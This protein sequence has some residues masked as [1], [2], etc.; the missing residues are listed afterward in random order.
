MSIMLHKILSFMRAPLA[1]RSLRPKFPKHF[2]RVEKMPQL[3]NVYRKEL[4]LQPYDMHLRTSI[5]LCLSGSLEW[6]TLSMSGRQSY[7]SWRLGLVR[8]NRSVVLTSRRRA[9]GSHPRTLKT[10]RNVDPKIANCRSATLLYYLG[11]F[12]K[13][14]ALKN[15]FITPN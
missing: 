4:R 14:S 13:A 3:S 7:Q 15:V 9:M 1:W 6:Q 8:K 12:R 11:S 10:E 5:L 2:L